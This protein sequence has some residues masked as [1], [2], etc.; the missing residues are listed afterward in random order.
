VSTAPS[1]SPHNDGPDMPEPAWPGETSGVMFE[2]D[3]GGPLGAPDELLTAPTPDGT[4]GVTIA[5][6]PSLDENR[7]GHHPSTPGSTWEPPADHAPDLEV[8]LTG[9]L[10]AIVKPSVSINDAL[11]ATV[12]RPARP[13]GGTAQNS[14][15]PGAGAGTALAPVA[16]G[17][18]PAA[19][20][21][22]IAE[23]QAEPVMG[24]VETDAASAEPELDAVFDSLRDQAADQLAQMPQRD[25]ATRLLRMAD[26]YQAAGMID[27][28]RAALEQAAQDPRY[29][30]RAMASLGR[31]IRKH[32]EPHD[33]LRWFEQAAEAPAPS[34]D[35][36]RALLYDLADT[37]ER[38]GES[39]R[40]LAVWLDLLAEQDDYR[41][42]RSRI[43]RL[44]RTQS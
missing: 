19:G 4:S 11:G 32:G 20:D 2:P 8:D 39:T 28:A 42:V 3:L 21:I 30:F 23:G 27:Q 26:T 36:G 15:A 35:D 17:V 41:D 25:Q 37:L 7:N 16:N 34:P 14:A 12:S 40:A 44:V 38:T 9:A 1:A 43:D 22:S 18:A 24:H 31:L 10:N 13:D 6:L 29:R 33:A 5:D